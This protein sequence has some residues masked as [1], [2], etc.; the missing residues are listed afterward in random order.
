[1]NPVTLD[2]LPLLAR[3]LAETSLDWMQ[4]YGKEGDLLLCPDHHGHYGVLDV[5]KHNVHMVRESAWWV[6]GLLL[7]NQGDDVARA[8]R[9]LDAVLRWQFNEPGMPYH[10]TF[11]RAPE[12]KLPTGLNAEMWGHYDPNWRQF[13][14][15]TWLILLELLAD[16]LTPE[17]RARL[18]ASIRLAVEGE[19]PDRIH[20]GYTNIAMMQAVLLVYAGRRFARPEWKERGVLLARKIHALFAEHGTFSEYNSPTYYGVTLQGLR[21]WRLFSQD[22][23]VEAWGAEMETALWQQTSRYYHPGLRNICGPFDRAYG[24]DMPRYVAMIGIWIRLAVEP[25]VAPCPSL[26]TE[27]DHAH[28]FCAAP[29]VALLGVEIPAEALRH[30]QEFHEDRSIHQIIESQ[31]APRIA[32]AFLQ[33]DRMWGAESGHG[34]SGGQFHAVTAHWRQP[35]GTTGWLRLLNPDGTTVDAVADAKGIRVTARSGASPRSL[36]WQFFSSPAAGLHLIGNE[37][38]LPGMRIRAT[39]SLPAPALQQGENGHNAIVYT[40]P[41]GH[42]TSFTLEFLPGE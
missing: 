33:A 1:M 10:G 31:P 9:I 5:S 40:L 37:W 6:A 38:H 32:T 14:G 26:T 3:Q 11:H 42:E 36:T 19:P 15:T 39:T 20:A 8:H 22:A 16:R 12:E 28:D 25:G 18:E 41:A 17:M 27:F 34:G 24:M 35:N 2:S 23:E 13:I 21:L 29:L 4:A 30:F 7:R